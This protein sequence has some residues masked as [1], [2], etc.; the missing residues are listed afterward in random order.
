[1]SSYMKINNRF[2]TELNSRLPSL[3]CQ[4][5]AVSK[6]HDEDAILEAYHVGQRIFGE[7][8]VQELV[9]KCQHLPD[10]IQWH[11]IGHLQTNKVKQIAPF[12]ALIHSVDSL[13]LMQEI[14]RQAERCNRCIDILLELHVAQEES[15]SGLTIEACRQLLQDGVWRQFTHIHIR[16]LMTM[17]SFVDDEQQIAGEFDRANAFWH[18]AQETFFAEEPAF[19]LRSW[20][21]SDDYEI[22]LRHGANMLRIG[23]AIFG[24]S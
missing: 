3:D 16:G 12:V 8:R 15:K 22:A 4:L 11:F 13:R 19:N 18:E 10:D 7:S 21:M 1:M 5:V 2:L 24:E 6:Y 17:A 20:G 23:S 14:E 9:P